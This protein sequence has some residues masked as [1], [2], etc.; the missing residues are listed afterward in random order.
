MNEKALERAA[1]VT[2]R[3]AILERLPPGPERTMWLR[4]AARLATS[5]QTPGAIRVGQAYRDALDG[6]ASQ[7][8]QQSDTYGSALRTRVAAAWVSRDSVPRLKRSERAKGSQSDPGTR[9]FR[10]AQ[11]RTRFCCARDLRRR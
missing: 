11:E 7:C 9:T 10:P 6:R 3:R 4:W 2:L 8:E 1:L 5:S